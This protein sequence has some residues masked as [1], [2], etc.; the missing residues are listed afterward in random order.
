MAMCVS[1]TS[2]AFYFDSLLGLTFIAHFNT[3]ILFILITPNKENITE[4]HE[5][6]SDIGGKCGTGEIWYKPRYSQLQ[7]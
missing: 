1:P 6:K 7:E 5:D 4:K 2:D 3:K